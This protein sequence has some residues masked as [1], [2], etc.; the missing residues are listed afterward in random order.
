M[1]K[2]IAF[3]IPALRGGGAEKVLVVLLR[4]LDR[5]R[6]DPVLIVFETCNE[7]PGELPGDV[8]TIALDAV[9][10]HG[11][12]GH[13]RLIAAIARVIRRETP[14]ILFSFMDYAN[15][16][17]S[18][19]RRIT[20]SRAKL[21]TSYQ[22]NMSMS[23]Q[24]GRLRS[25][26]LIKS[27]L[28]NVVYTG[29]DCVVCVSQ[30]VMDDLVANWR[31]PREKG[32]V[33]YN[34][35]ESD[36]IQELAREQ[37]EHPWFQEKRPIIVSCGRLEREKNY[38]LLLRAF[39]HAK[40][41]VPEVRLVILGKGRLLEHLVRQAEELNIADS[42]SFAG[43][44]KNPFKYMA[45]AKFLVLSSS[46]EGFANV[47]VESMTCGTPVIS[48]RCPS[49]P[50]E[51]ITDNENGLLVPV[52]DDQELARAMVCLLND[53]DLRRR[54]SE[55]GKMRAEAFNIPSILTSYEDLLEEP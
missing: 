17:A 43:F 3:I 33:I 54:L 50:D 28:A 53:D 26:A 30:G 22:S 25:R 31:L 10:K 37:V 36:R 20:R 41:E 45:R 13:V 46:W 38:S 29:I 55:G 19:A 39:A 21:Y 7:Y 52:E 5:A 47:L 44:Q 2:K 16:C 49:G 4:H 8:R 18:I 6:F 32:R 42:I 15:H 12:A 1:R 35:V 40:K 51:I 48:T 11:F 23:Y 24:P 14:D 9:N 34:P 27:I